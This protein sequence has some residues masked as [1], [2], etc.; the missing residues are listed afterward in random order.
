MNSPT[1]P[2][3]APP[4]PM[5]LKAFLETV[6]VLEPRDVAVT[7]TNAQYCTRLS[8]PSIHHY[9]SV[10]ECAGIRRFDSETEV[11]FHFNKDS[12]AF[13]QS[14][15]IYFCRNC[16]RGWKLYALKLR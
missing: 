11:V 7:L 10:S 12:K 9:C 1:V 8:L 3:S 2:A 6:P 14:F 16:K 5:S 4:A 13:T 15:V